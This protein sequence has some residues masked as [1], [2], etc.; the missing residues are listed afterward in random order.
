M[1]SVIGKDSPDGMT[2]RTVSICSVLWGHPTDVRGVIK[3][4]SCTKNVL[5]SS[6]GKELIM[7]MRDFT[8]PLNAWASLLS[9]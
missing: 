4:K 8:V 5:L 9:D 7:Q 6:A 2:K 3:N 1:H